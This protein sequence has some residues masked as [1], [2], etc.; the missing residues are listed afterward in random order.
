MTSNRPYLIRAIYDWISDND[1]TP[2]I[3]VNADFADV[4]VP[5]RYV[6]DGK[7]VLNISARAV[8]LLDLGNVAIEFTARFDGVV[9]QVHVP[10]M[11]V[12]AIYS[13]ENGRGMVFHEDDS[14]DDDTPKEGKAKPDRGGDGKKGP[15]SLRVVT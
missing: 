15:P 13:F 2:Y 5:L 7:I 6:A 10:I 12:D 11:A 8:K 9:Q 4:Q 1:L 14:G 3:M